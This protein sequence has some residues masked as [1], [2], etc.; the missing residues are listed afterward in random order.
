[1]STLGTLKIETGNSISSS[2]SSLRDLRMLITH[3]N[4][5]KFEPKLEGIVVRR[6]DMSNFMVFF[7]GGGGDALFGEALVPVGMVRIRVL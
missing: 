5:S 4:S 3:R 6:E 7:F 1:M 2:S